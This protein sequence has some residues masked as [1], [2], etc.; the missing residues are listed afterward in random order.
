MKQV[1]QAAKVGAV[2]IDPVTALDN[3]LE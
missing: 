3:I 2:V 1:R